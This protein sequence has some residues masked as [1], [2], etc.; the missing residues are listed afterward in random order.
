[1]GP[2]NS[3][4][5]PA[6]QHPVSGTFISDHGIPEQTDC[7]DL[8]DGQNEEF[9]Y[10][11]CVPVFLPEIVREG[12]LCERLPPGSPVSRLALVASF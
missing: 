11:E 3:E 1:M 8:D 6:D 4:K 9:F 7:G 2:D 10:P 5:N 12:F